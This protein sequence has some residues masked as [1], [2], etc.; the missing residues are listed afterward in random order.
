[1][2]MLKNRLAALAGV[3][4]LAGAAAL[5]TPGVFAVAAEGSLALDNLTFTLGATTYRIP[6]LELEGANLPA[7]DL[8]GLFLGDEKTVDGRL[9]RLSARRLTIPAFTTERRAGDTVERATYRDVAAEGVVGGRIGVMRAGSVEQVVEKPDGTGQSFLWSRA[10]LKG[11][12]LRQ[13]A[14]MVMATRLDAQ[15][16]MKPLID[17]ESVE[18]LAM[19]DKGGRLAVKT[20]RFALT[21]VKGRALAAAP[22]Q[23]LERLQR[24]D[25]DHAEADPTLLKDLIE[26]VASVEVSSFEVRD[27][28][29]TGKG[30]PH[31][32]PY[33]VKLG[34]FAAS[35]LANGSIGEIA[36]DDFGLAASDGG[37]IAI[38]RLGLRDA[39]LVSFV[40]APFP[41][42]GHVGLEGLA[43][44]VPDARLESSRMKVTLAGAEANFS[45]FREIAPTKFNARLDRFAIDLA[46]RG[47]APSTAQFLAL[48]Y[49]DLDV[50][51]SL[52]GEWREKTQE[53]VFAPLRIES[54]DMGAA[55]LNVTFANVSSAVFSSM[56]IVSKA[57]ALASSLKSVELTVEGGGL[58]DRL[59]A[60][61]AKQEKM[62]LDKARADYAKTAGLAVAAIFGGGEKAKKIADAVSAYILKPKRL[63][64]RLS[65]PS[66]INALEM[67]AKR[68]MDILEGLEAQAT[69]ER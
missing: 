38:R 58:V 47:E 3:F 25:P 8:A 55:T 63:V 42:I 17:E 62:P 37:K 31:D 20:G 11:L 64:V 27:I 52:A 57:A 10:L 24:L 43:A 68:P 65:S 21:G 19:S 66:G 15:E 2:Q 32:A 45:D 34:K 59:L 56:A 7:A 41:Q 69:A 48:G 54:K 28:V 5:A 16:A 46:A 22:A 30:E 23:L 50:S 44:D 39:R 4:L 36:L 12:D 61:E 60:L 1:M 49:R 6:H 40:D 29:L 13:A 9:A 14:R 53:A 35:R 26:A 33:A 18:T 51:A 67:A